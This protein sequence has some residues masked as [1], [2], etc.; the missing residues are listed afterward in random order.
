M[1][2][3]SWQEDALR[4]LLEAWFGPVI[5]AVWLDLASGGGADSQAA[6]SPSVTSS[7]AQATTPTTATSFT[8]TNLISDGSVPA[9]Q[10]DPNLINPWG[11]SYGS[12]GTGGEFWISDGGTGLTS[13]DTVTSSAVSLNLFLRSPSR[14]DPRA[15]PRHRPAR[16]TTPS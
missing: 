6:A 8:Q 13:I 12:I 7:G 3:S 10:T 5:Q 2:A 4:Y 15:A 14:R 1:S 16:S 9:E 11:I